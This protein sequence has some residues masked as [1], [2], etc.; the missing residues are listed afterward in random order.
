MRVLIVTQ[1][2]WGRR[3]ARHL[4]GTAPSDWV[5]ADW[6]GPVALPM[7]LDDPEEYLPDA[8]PRADLLLVLTESAG[9]TD[10]S[11][12]IAQLCGAQAVIVPVDR[13]SWTG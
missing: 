2:E 12:D 5:L 7:V 4:H 6:Q 10:L 9:M 3:I 1:E 13:R 8:L 11:S